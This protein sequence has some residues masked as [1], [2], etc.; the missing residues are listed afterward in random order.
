MQIDLDYIP[1]SFDT[2]CIM[3]RFLSVSAPSKSS[4][5]MTSRLAAM[6]ASLPASV[7][8]ECSTGPPPPE[9]FSSDICA[10]N[11]KEERKTRADKKRASHG[12]KKKICRSRDWNPGTQD[13][14]AD[15]PPQTTRLDGGAAQQLRSKAGPGAQV[16]KPF[17]CCFW[18]GWLPGMCWEAALTWLLAEV[19]S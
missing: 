15:V 14:D 17:C 1:I 2:L 11:V 3:L 13:M 6:A 7:V 5:S 4:L 19:P 12:G 18:G 16:Y 9:L 10:Q 8:L